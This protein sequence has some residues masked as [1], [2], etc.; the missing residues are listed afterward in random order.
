MQI[1]SFVPVNDCYRNLI[2]V[3]DF[4]LILVTA[5]EFKFCILFSVMALITVKLECSI[6]FL[7]YCC[8]VL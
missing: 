5:W 1:F 7:L 6:L 8:S 4:V 3:Y 2:K